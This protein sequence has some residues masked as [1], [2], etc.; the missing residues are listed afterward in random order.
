MTTTVTTPQDLLPLVGQTLGTTEWVSIDQDRV[1]LFA[2]A[3]DDHQWIHVDPEKAAN[4]PFGGIIAHGYLTLSLAPVLLQE[5]VVVEEFSAALNYG[6]NKV[7]FPSPV[8]VGS[9]LRATVDLVSAQDKNGAIEAV[10]RLTYEVDGADRPACIAE[11]VV[12]YR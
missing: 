1:N 4:G 10:F 6:L 11:T 2:D 9:R 8:P 12:L 3:T 7:R 5:A